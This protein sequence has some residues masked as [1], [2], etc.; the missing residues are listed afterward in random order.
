MSS[1]TLDTTVLIKGIIPPRRRK[2]D[3]IYEEQLR[4]HRIAKS[5]IANVEAGQDVMNIPAVA[6]I[7]VAAVGARLTGKDERGIEAAE[8]VKQH[9]NIIYDI[10]LLDEAVKMASKTK[11]SGFD[12]IFLRDIK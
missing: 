7:E 10:Y 11:V 6:I 8:Y 5:I 1:L 4:L 12:N 3:S 9:G 2:V